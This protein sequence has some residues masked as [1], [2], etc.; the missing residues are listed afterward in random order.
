LEARTGH[1]VVHLA[2]CPGWQLD[3]LAE[4]LVGAV[5][6]FPVCFFTSL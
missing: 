2:V 3:V 1:R 5:S 4:R 6:F